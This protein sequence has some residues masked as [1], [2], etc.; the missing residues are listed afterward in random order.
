[1]RFFLPNGGT[2]RITYKLQGTEMRFCARTLGFKYAYGSPPLFYLLYLVPYMFDKRHFFFFS[3][4]Q[5]NVAAFPYAG[6]VIGPLNESIC[7][8]IQMLAQLLEQTKEYKKH[9]VQEAY[10]LL[11]PFL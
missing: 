4:L 6:H 10:I 1:M 2:N 8:W 5:E 7:N 3:T 11:N 9:I